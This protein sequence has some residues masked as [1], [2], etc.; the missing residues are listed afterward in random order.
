[1]FLETGKCNYFVI[2]TLAN[3]SS[4]LRNAVSVTLAVFLFIW[5]YT[6]HL[7][8]PGRA[9]HSTNNNQ[10]KSRKRSSMIG[11][12]REAVSGNSKAASLNTCRPPMKK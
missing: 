6:L 2:L 4:F 12:F 8:N 1:M 7:R 10:G 5:S 11:E 9:T 3:F